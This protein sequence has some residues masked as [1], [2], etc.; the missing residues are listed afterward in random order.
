MVSQKI[1]EKYIA[2]GG[3]A[4][5]EHK[6]R[7]EQETMYVAEDCKHYG[8]KFYGMYS[9]FTVMTQHTY[10]TKEDLLFVLGVM[11]SHKDEMETDTHEFYK[12]MTETREN[13]YELAE[14][15][16]LEEMKRIGKL[17]GVEVIA[18]NHNEAYDKYFDHGGKMMAHNYFY[19][20]R[21]GKVLL[22]ECE[23]VVGG[24]NYE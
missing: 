13:A 2:L 22:H 11:S 18:K 1:R 5:V 17:E 6:A 21:M 4:A 9:C 15:E 23:A 19:H 20:F 3:L 14:Q 7:F 8:G 16:T 24:L 10:G 12:S